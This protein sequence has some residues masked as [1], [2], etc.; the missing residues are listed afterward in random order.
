MTMYN[1]RDGEKAIIIRDRFSKS[2]KTPRWAHL[3]AC[4]I[5]R[6]NKYSVTVRIENRKGYQ[7]V[8]AK[9]L[10]PL[11]YIVETRHGLQEKETP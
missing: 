6:Y 3:Y 5:V 8:D 2:Y 4:E 10:V 7:H 1:F 11:G 9:D